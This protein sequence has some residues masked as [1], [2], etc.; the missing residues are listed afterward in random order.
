MRYYNNNAQG[1][2]PLSCRQGVVLL[3]I[4]FKEGFRFREEIDGFPD[5]G[6]ILAVCLPT[7]FITPEKTGNCPFNF[8]LDLVPS[9]LEFFLFVGNLL[10]LQKALEVGQE[11]RVGYKGLIKNL[12]GFCSGRLVFPASNG[13]VLG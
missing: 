2:K 12:L 6:I 10:F 4:I 1:N 5:N 13:E 9:L 3:R 8:A 7:S 11:F